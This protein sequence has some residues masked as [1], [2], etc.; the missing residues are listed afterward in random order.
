LLAIV[1]SGMGVDYGTL[2]GAHA[3]TSVRPTT[4]RCSEKLVRV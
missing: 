2:S 4:D 1:L 3:P